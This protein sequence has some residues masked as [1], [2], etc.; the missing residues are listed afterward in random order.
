MEKW[1]EV[2]VGK[3]PKG[4]YQTQITNGEEKGLNISLRNEVYDI[5]IYFGY[6]QAVRIL[7]EGIVQ[8]QLYSEQELMEYRKDNFSNIIYK[9]DDGEFEKQV[10]KIS[11]DLWDTLNLKHYILITSN[12]NIDILTEWKPEIEIR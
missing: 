7:D 12:F 5:S 3:I 8:E 10:Q 9:V 1:K 2:F 4:I 6:V 11:G